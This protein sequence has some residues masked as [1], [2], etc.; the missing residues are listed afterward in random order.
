MRSID[1]HHTGTM[2]SLPTLRAWLGTLDTADLER[3]LTNV[4][5]TSRGAQ[6]R[7]LDELSERLEHP[8]AVSETLLMMPAPLVQAVEAALAL[9]EMATL[10]SLTELL[11]ADHAEQAHHAAAVEHWVDVAADHALLWRDGDRL[12][13]NP[14]LHEVLLRPLGLPGPLATF[15]TDVTSDVLASVLRGHGRPQPGQRKALRLAA[16]RD[17]FADPAGLRRLAGTAPADVLTTLTEHIDHELRTSRALM[18]AGPDDIDTADDI[19]LHQITMASYHARKQML[20][21]MRRSGLSFSWSWSFEIGIPSEVYLALRPPWYRAPFAPVPPAPALVEVPDEQAGRTASAATTGF[22]A[23]AMAVLET[24]AR[25]GVKELKAGGIGTREVHRLAKAAGTDVA[26]VRLTLTLAHQL[27]LLQHSATARDTVIVSE[28]FDA[29]RRASPAERLRD[30]YLAWL[31]LDV[32]PTLDRY[33]DEPVHPLGRLPQTSGMPAGLVLLQLLAGV[34]GQAVAQAE[35][36]LALLSW[37]HPLTSTAPGSL[38][39]TWA[40]ATTLGLVADGRLTRAG[41]ALIQGDTSAVVGILQA[42]LPEV[43]G[44]VMFGSDLTVVVP[45]S[46][47]PHTVDVL[48]TLATREGHG[49]ANTWRVSPSSVREALDA[50]YDA[51][52]LLAGLR[53]IAAKEL[54][55]ALEYLLADVARKHGHLRVRAATTVLTCDDEAL[56]AEV[57]AARSLRSLGLHTIAPTVATATAPPAKVLAAL[58][59]SG[60][61]PVEAGDGGAPLVGLRRL[62]ER[63]PAV[64]T[65]VTDAGPNAVPGLPVGNG[66]RS[67]EHAGDP[68]RAGH[69]AQLAR[70]LLEGSADHGTDELE[71]AVAAQARHLSSA[72]SHELADAVRAGRPVQIRYRNASGRTSVRLVSEMTVTG[73]HLLGFCHSKGE[74]RMFRLDQI[75]AV[76]PSIPEM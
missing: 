55:Q 66:G 33:D 22:L 65:P 18:T 58:R 9:G 68:G 59:S 43:S 63:T 39:A 14:G 51:E 25:T 57:V 37:A 28:E 61:L 19:D 21:W 40:E 34:E 52:D 24:L 62:P 17:C 31:P 32:A 29:W 4:P 8:G 45:G 71:Q 60:Y 6:V 49:V 27:T 23:A 74:E 48:D 72:E 35:D 12:R 67:P 10:D 38:P 64:S 3:L 50:G 7:N 20:D 13:T 2:T 73:S 41:D 47:D 54:P 16:V 76:I 42:M 53:D 70:A 30:L 11:E 36:L 26:I 56:L 69:A 44:Q 46:P 75:L 1:I 15:L 5:F